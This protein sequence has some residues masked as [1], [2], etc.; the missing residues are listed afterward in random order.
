MVLGPSTKGHGP[1]R[2]YD[3]SMAFFNGLDHHPQLIEL[4]MP[5]LCQ[6]RIQVSWELS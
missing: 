2:I 1:V 4:S 3:A 5:R 6:L